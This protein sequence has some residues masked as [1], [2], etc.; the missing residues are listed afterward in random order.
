MVLSRRST[1]AENDASIRS[2]SS[3]AVYGSVTQAY[4]VIS[5]PRKGKR[6]YRNGPNPRGCAAAGTHPCE[7][8]RIRVRG[9]RLLRACREIVIETVMRP[10][11]AMPP[12]PIDCGHDLGQRSTPARW[13]KSGLA[14]VAAGLTP[15][16]MAG[17]ESQNPPSSRAS[18]HAA[19]AK[20]A[21]RPAR[22]PL[23]GV[24]L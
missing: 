5:F 8:L 18:H 11:A 9:S 12:H 7:P 16:T 1:K 2:R 23:I 17:A 10:S 24:G 15:Q 3:S 6:L 19:T 22:F 14:L 4:D 20:S 13:R 21:D